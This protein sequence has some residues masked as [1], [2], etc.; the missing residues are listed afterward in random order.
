MKRTFDFHD[1]KTWPEYFEAI[2][3]EQKTFEVRKDDRTFKVGD[4]LRL[5]EFDP[6]HSRYSGR[7]IPVEVTYILKGG[8][9]GIEPGYCVMGFKASDG[10]TS[11]FASEKEKPSTTLQDDLNTLE[12]A[13]S[14][15]CDTPGCQPTMGMCI[16]ARCVWDTGSQEA[17]S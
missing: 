17:E 9:F 8:Q 15:D 3:L 16:H 11:S 5:Q 14:N 10:F 4:I 2:R 12:R 6:V 1:M 13:Q 7:Y